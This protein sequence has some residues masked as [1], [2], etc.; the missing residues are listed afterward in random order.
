MASSASYAALVT[1]HHTVASAVARLDALSE[2]E[3][4]NLA[5]ISSGSFYFSLDPTAE[6][7]AFLLLYPY[8]KHA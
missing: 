4:N 7:K 5:S 2:H 3:K 1:G 8:R 6:E